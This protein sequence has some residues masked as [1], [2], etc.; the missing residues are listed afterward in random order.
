MRIARIT[1]AIVLAL[2]G[3]AAAAATVVTPRATVRR[4]VNIH[5][6]PLLRPDNVIYRLE[7]AHC[8]RL[9][10]RAQRWIE[11]WLPD[12]RVG[13]A[14]A[15]VV[16]LLP[17]EQLNVEE[18]GF[19]VRFMNAGGGD[20]TL[21]RMG[22]TEV[23]VDGGADGTAL[24]RELGDSIHWPLDLL[25]VASK[26]REH[27][28]GLQSLVAQ[29]SSDRRIEEIWLPPPDGRCD[30][31]E[32]IGF[33]ER[34]RR[35]P[36]T[37][38]RTPSEFTQRRREPR[39]APEIDFEIL[40]AGIPPSEARGCPSRLDNGS[41][42]FIAI[43]GRYR[44]LFTSDIW[45]RDPGSD[46]N[47]TGPRYLEERLV[48]QHSRDLRVDVVKIPNHGRSVTNT[49]SFVRELQPRS[50]SLH[51]VSFGPPDDR[52]SRWYEH[53]GI[54]VHNAGASTI[55]CTASGGSDVVCASAR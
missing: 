16:D 11:V 53:R 38:I 34:L 33:V 24:L 43:A 35:L 13:F 3:T 32:Y 51:A 55:T 22:P 19:E 41:L 49:P 42:V 40:H 9:K 36:R 27:W 7:P 50:T 18:L 44:A 5:S 52:I 23:L 25:I 17:S 12:D 20:A 15:D 54:P 39:S 6:E 47:V 10:Q 31:R 8:L 37:I 29:T 45:G 26:K 2:Y 30:S 21:I 28:S 46:T 14:A 4:F 48:N 1:G